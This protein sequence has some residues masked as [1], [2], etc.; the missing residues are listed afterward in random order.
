MTIANVIAF[1]LG[2]ALLA[3]AL[4]VVVACVVTGHV[5]ACAGGLVD[6]L[7]WPVAVPPWP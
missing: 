6:A 5:L 1:L 3:V 2:G 7:R 4:L